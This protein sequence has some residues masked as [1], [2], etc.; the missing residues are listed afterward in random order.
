M[1]SFISKI[2]SNKKLTGINYSFISKVKE[3]Y[4]NKINVGEYITERLVEKNIR[5]GFGYNGGAALSFFDIISSNSNFDVIFNRHEQNSGHAAEAYG[6]ITNNVGI[7]I[8]TSGPGFTNVITPLQDAYSDGIPLLC[9]SCQVNSYSLGTD[10]FQECDATSI[11][12]SC[13]KDNF[14]VKNTEYFPNILEYM[15]NLSEDPKSGPVHLDI[16]KDVFTQNINLKDI[17]LEETNGYSE[18]QYLEHLYNNTYN[19]DYTLLKEKIINSKKPILIAGAGAVKDYKLV[20]EFSK[21]YNIPVATT[22]HGLGIMNE[23]DDLSLKMIGMHGSYQANMAIED[24]DLVIGLGN[25]Y[26]DR[27]IG[28][29]KSFALSAKNGEGLIHIDNSMKQIAK[30]RSILKPTM[31]IKSNS[32]DVLKYLIDNYESKDFASRTEWKNQISKWKSSFKLDSSD[33]LTS[34][35]IIEYLSNK[36]KNKDNYILTTGVGSHQMVCAQY[37]NHELPN[38]LIT[39][40]SLG[41]MGVGLPF[42]IGAQIASPN[43]DIIL[44]DGDGSFT[45]NS[46]EI[47]TIKEYN[48]PIKIFIMNDSKLKMVDLWQELFYKNRKVGSN[49]IYTPEFHKLGEAYGI[50]NYICTNKNEMKKIVDAALSCD[51]A[52]I[53]NF[54]IQDSL[55]LPFVPPNKRLSEMVTHL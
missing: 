23:N 27:T 15:L 51:E 35:E 17:I 38:K 48:L 40:G 39:S 24:S 55:C 25:R 54:K 44:I 49:F 10:A 18:L 12:R 50:K 3:K 45:M 32:Y 46:N 1:T 43:S 42:S 47:A 53:V 52:V 41:T 26:D 6:K 2:I 19:N 11:T 22:L 7:V 14:L 37:F 8:T 9:I 34:N 16:C 5:K 33:I 13:V 21:L 30:V 20:R 28:N 36:L 29:K 4:N 31:S